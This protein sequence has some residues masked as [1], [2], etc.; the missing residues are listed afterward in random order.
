M[1]GCLR[2]RHVFKYVK[3]ELLINSPLNSFFQLA[4]KSKSNKYIAVVVGCVCVWGDMFSFVVV[5]FFIF[6]FLKNHRTWVSWEKS[7]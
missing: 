1:Q 7:C 3:L 6:K 2:N 5:V 4:E